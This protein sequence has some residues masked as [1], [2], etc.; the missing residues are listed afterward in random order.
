[1]PLLFRGAC[2]S[3]PLDAYSREGAVEVGWSSSR[4]SRLSH[5]HPIERRPWVET[6]HDK[7]RA[8]IELGIA[9]TEP[10]ADAFVT[11]LLDLATLPSFGPKAS[12]EVSLCLFLLPPPSPPRGAS[13]SEMHNHSPTAFTCRP[14]SDKQNAA[15]NGAQDGENRMHGL[16][17]ESRTGQSRDY[18]DIAAVGTLGRFHFDVIAGIKSV[19]EG[20]SLDRSTGLSLGLRRRG[21]RHSE[22]WR[23]N[24]GACS[25]GF[26]E[27]LARA[28]GSACGRVAQ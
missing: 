25:V 11:Q 16:I 1:M 27:A 3:P 26:A 15:D 14:M 22:G 19:P 28:A 13:L 18:V 20:C 7:D 10:T 24:I 17:V 21:R 23:G 8:R 9:A 4:G 5:D 2:E 6:L 12:S